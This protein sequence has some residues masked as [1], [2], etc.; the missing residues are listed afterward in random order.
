RGNS[1][2]LPKNDNLLKTG[3]LTLEFL[4]PIQPDDERFG[5]N[6]SERTKKISTYFKQ[7][8]L[9]LKRAD[10]GEDYFKNKLKFNYIYKPRVIQK[11]FWSDFESNKK[12]YHE[13]LHLIPPKAKVFHGGCGYGVLGFLL[14]YD[15]A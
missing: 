12:A 3:K 13:I 9:E 15:S 5:Q 4:P 8:F 1:D 7:K 14:V 2:L 6:Y 11:T 10:E